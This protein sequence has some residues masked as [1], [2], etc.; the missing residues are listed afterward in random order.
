[1]IKATRKEGIRRRSF[2]ARK[3]CLRYGY[4]VGDKGV[5]GASYLGCGVNEAGL[6]LGVPFTLSTGYGGPTALRKAWGV[7]LCPEIVILDVDRFLVKKC[8]EGSYKQ[9]YQPD[10]TLDS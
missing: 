6:C 4:V 8:C 9:S 10:G 5:D 1:M 7:G 2:E 3:P